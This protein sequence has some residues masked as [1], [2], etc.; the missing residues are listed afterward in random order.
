MQSVWES[1][2][3]HEILGEDVPTKKRDGSYKPTSQP[4]KSKPAKPPSASGS[5]KKLELQTTTKTK[6]TEQHGTGRSQL[7]ASKS[8]FSM[9][10]ELDMEL[11][12]GEIVY[13]ERSDS[14]EEEG[15][16][17]IKRPGPRRP[18]YVSDD[19]ESTG[20]HQMEDR[21]TTAD[22]QDL[23]AKATPAKKPRNGIIKLDRKREYWTSKS[24][25]IVIDNTP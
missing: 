7:S 10:Q 17:S 4:K 9:D 3:L 24:G 13:V 11:S 16:Y 20:Y 1:G 21:K 15:K 6:S 8:K 5:S 22:S 23:P 25:A 2:A 19:E 12:D 14:E 18:I